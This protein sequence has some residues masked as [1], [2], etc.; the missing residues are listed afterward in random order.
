MDDSFLYSCC[1]MLPRCDQTKAGITKYMELRPSWEAVSHSCPQE[2]PSILW[3][4]KVH[5]RVHKS[6]SLVPILNQWPQSIPRHPISL[7]PNFILS[8][9]LFR[10]FLLS[11]HQN[12]MCISL[13][14]HAC[15]I[16]CPS[17]LPWLDHSNY[18]WRRVSKL[19][20]YFKLCHDRFLPHHFG[21]IIQLPNL[22]RI[23]NQL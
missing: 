15:C 23:T 22:H 7:R 1:P 20:F 9:H 10:S 19:V 11:S 3:N 12:H 8:S 17:H 13:L 6:S 14:C 5:Y 16:S 21:F 2:L 18:I 4:P